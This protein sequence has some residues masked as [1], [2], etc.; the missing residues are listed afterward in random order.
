MPKT[1][2]I[3][4]SEDQHDVAIVDDQ[5]RVV[6]RAR[7]RDNVAGFSQLVELLAQHGELASIEIAIETDKGLLV[8]ALVGAGFPVFPINPQQLLG[9]ASL[10][11]IWD[12]SR[13]VCPAVLDGQDGQADG[14]WLGFELAWGGS[15]RCGGVSKLVEQVV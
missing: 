7:I 3:D 10:C 6:A 13:S 1:C 5:A 14:G 15:C 11:G 8:A 9:T 4:W 2:G 12:L